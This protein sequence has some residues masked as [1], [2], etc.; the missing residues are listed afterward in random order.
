MSKSIFSGEE[1]ETLIKSTSKTTESSTKKL[2]QM[3]KTLDEQE[4]LLRGYQFENEKLYAEIKELKEAN[5]RVLNKY[6]EEKQQLKFDLIQEKKIIHERK[7]SPSPTPPQLPLPLL[8]A[9][10][11]MPTN[12]PTQPRVETVET[13][14]R[15]ITQL[16]QRLNDAN[17]L[18]RDLR[19]RAENYEQLKQQ[20]ESDMRVINEKNKEIKGLNEK[21]KQLEMGK[22]APEY[23]KDL[24]QVKNQLKEMDLL[25]KRLRRSIATQATNGMP[26]SSEANVNISLD[27]YEKRIE[28]LEALLREKS[29]DL[30][31]LN[32]LFGMNK[33]SNMSGVSSQPWVFLSFI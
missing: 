19:S 3:K 21:L 33:N 11:F 8:D 7:S 4:L 28:K 17:A 9:N 23:L 29:N 18:S 30:D 20:L 26:S 2:E 13:Y 1:E 10:K 22:T 6:E 31:R 12:E 15:H 32:C 25:V 27:F 16:E 24:R 5:R 14:E